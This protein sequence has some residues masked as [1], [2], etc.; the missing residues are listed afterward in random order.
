MIFDTL[1]K[2]VRGVRFEDK[3]EKVVGL[4]VLYVSVGVFCVLANP[5]KITV[6]ENNNTIT[7][8]EL[9]CH[10]RTSFL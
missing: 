3:V 4:V 5:Y 2:F 7:S 6:K 9:Q 8:H 1:N 10:I